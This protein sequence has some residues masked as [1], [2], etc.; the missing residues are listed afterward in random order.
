MASSSLQSWMIST[1][2]EFLTVLVLSTPWCSHPEYV[3]R[4]LLSLS[5]EHQT[6]LSRITLI[7]DVQAAWLLLA[8]SAAARVKY[9]LRCET[10]SQ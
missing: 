2:S 7:E 5:N 6:L 4:F 9:S 3:R 8:H 1:L 10:Q